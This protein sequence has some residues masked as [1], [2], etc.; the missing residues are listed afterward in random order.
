MLIDRIAEN[1][2]QLLSDEDKN[3]IKGIIKGDLMGKYPD[4]GI[5]LWFYQYSL[6]VDDSG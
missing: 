3:L 2:S 5:F 6:D 1:N 4:K